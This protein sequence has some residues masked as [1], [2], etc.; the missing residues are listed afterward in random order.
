[1]QFLL[2]AMQV[3]GSIPGAAPSFPWGPAIVKLLQLS[4]LHD[5]EA[6]VANPAQ[7]DQFIEQA[8]AQQQTAADGGT[9]TNPQ[10]QQP[11][12]PEIDL[13]GALGNNG[14]VQ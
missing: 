10:G 1:M 13:V 9:A 2:Q 11:G 14:S 4:N 8:L 5:I 12:L 3:I 7:M 6:M